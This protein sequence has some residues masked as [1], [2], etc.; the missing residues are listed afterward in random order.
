M[1]QSPDDEKRDETLKRMLAMAP[2]PHGSSKKREADAPRPK[3]SK[4]D[5]G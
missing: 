3:L 4:K 5:K 1:S 2:D